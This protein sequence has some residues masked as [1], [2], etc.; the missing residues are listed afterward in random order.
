MSA[1]GRQSAAL[2]PSVE[3]YMLGQV[4]FDACLSLQQRLVYEQSGRDDGQIA[5]VICEHPP[6]VTVG[7][8]GSRGHIRFDDRQL[9]SARLNLRWINR[10]GGCLLHTPGQLAVYPIVPLFWHGF[11]VGDYLGRL[12]Q[13]LLAALAD[14]KI[15]TS[16]RS[17]RFDIWG[18]CGKLATLGVAV[19]GWTSYFGA[20][21][22]VCPPMDAV[23]ELLADPDG[24]ASSLATERQDPIRMPRVR[25][26]VVR[27]L[28]EAFGCQRY[29]YYTSHPLWQPAAP[30]E[31]R[32]T[33]QA[34]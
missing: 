1:A 20:F 6:L 34:G 25:E 17:N 19:K 21:L 30:V 27:H 4:D 12:Q 33:A 14:L 32:I 10:G 23:H 13:G 31:Q 7:R 24:A 2:G 3:A 5:L 15:V 11:S 8:Q 9:Q 26:S 29:H 16:T 18:R 28:A 22:N